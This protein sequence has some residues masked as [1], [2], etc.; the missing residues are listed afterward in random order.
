[1]SSIA[2]IR[3]TFHGFSTLYRVQQKGWAI[4]LSTPKVTEEIANRG[5][6]SATLGNLIA[7]RATVFNRIQHFIFGSGVQINHLV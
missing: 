5:S 3:Y 1:M 2:T 4:F 6:T 7:L